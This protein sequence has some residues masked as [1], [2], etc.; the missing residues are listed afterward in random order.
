MIRYLPTSFRFPQ[1]LPILWGFLAVG[2]Q[3]EPSPHDIAPSQTRLVMAQST[4]AAAAVSSQAVQNQPVVPL[5]S[6]ESMPPAPPP[7]ASAPP[8]PPA[9]EG[10]VLDPRLDPRQPKNCQLNLTTEQTLTCGEISVVLPAGTYDQNTIVENP[11]GKRAIGET[12]LRPQQVGLGYI[13]YLS[14]TPLKINGVERTGG[15]DVPI[16]EEDKLPV[17]IWYRKMVEPDPITKAFSFILPPVALAA[18]LGAWSSGNILLP[19]SA[20]VFTEARD[21]YLKPLKPKPN[22]NEIPLPSH[23]R[24]LQDPYAC[25]SSKVRSK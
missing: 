12:Y 20:P 22:P 11:E 15:L 6:G 14:D 21:Y 10:P 7:P 4:P 24:P 2:A 23:V 18:G 25:S 8:S 17:R 3:A 16:R 1:V 13:R 19:D 9:E 5:R